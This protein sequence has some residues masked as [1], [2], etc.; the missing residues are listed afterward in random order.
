VSVVLLDDACCLCLL[1]FGMVPAG[2]SMLC[3]LCF[4]M[5]PAGL[6]LCPRGRLAQLALRFAAAQLCTTEVSCC[7]C[8]CCLYTGAALLR[9]TRLPRPQE[10][11]SPHVPRS[12]SACCTLSRCTS[13]GGVCKNLK[14]QTCDQTDLTAI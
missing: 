7:C 1:C 3:L 8:C 4:G 2:R 9:P 5:L 14:I 12:V 6:C 10:A 13:P 11:G